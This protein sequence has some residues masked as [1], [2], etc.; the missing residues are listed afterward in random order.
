M[1]YVFNAIILLAVIFV[2]RMAACHDTGNPETEIETVKSQETDFSGARLLKT[3]KNYFSVPQSVVLDGK[4]D[5]IYISNIVS[6]TVKKE[7]SGYV[8][9]A[10]LSGE[11]I[12]TLNIAGLACPKGM[13]VGDGVLFIADGV[14]LLEYGIQED[15]VVKE[16]QIPGAEA[17]NDVVIS[18]KGTVYV[19]DS[20]GNCIYK[21]SDGGADVF[22]SSQDYTLTGV[23][24]FDDGFLYTASDKKILKISEKANVEVFKKMK[25]TPTGIKPDGKGGFLVASNSDGI[26]AMTK[27]SSELIVKKRQKVYYADFEYVDQQK[28]LFAPTGLDNSLEIYEVGQYF[29]PAK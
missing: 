23:M 1:K 7:T 13:A 12:D 18:G 3:C 9:R 26:Y 5:I 8:C 27:D 11:V 16:Y 25:F 24:C 22:F 17:L 15:S 2:I 28:M 10:G 29:Q 19:S 21:I 6:D 4:N 20:Q 14:R